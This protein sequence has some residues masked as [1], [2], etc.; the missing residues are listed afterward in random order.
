LC[1]HSI[2]PWPD[3]P[4]RLAIGISAAGVWVTDDGGGSWRKGFDGLVPRYA[5]D[6]APEDAVG[7]CV[8]DIKR[9]P[10]APDTM[11]MQFH[12]GVYRSDDTGETWA[13]IGTDR[14]LPSDFGFPLVIDPTDS[15]RAFVIPL[16]GDFDRTTPEGKVRVY[17]TIDGGSTWEAR[18]NGLPDR[19]AYLTVLRQAFCCDG[20]GGGDLDLYFGATS[21]DVFG[22]VDGG[23]TWSTIA[24]HLPPVLSVRSTL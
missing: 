12:G 23:A 9:S 22:S 13:D 15:R 18:G 3:D 24:R 2:C 5:P 21:G 8:H 17:E 16:A 4:A 19:D 7:L 6:G 14:G 1:L 20:G 11:Y 10:V